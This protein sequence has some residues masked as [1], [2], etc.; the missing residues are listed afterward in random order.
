MYNGH[1]PTAR[2]PFGCN[3]HAKAVAV[4]KAN[5]FILVPESLPGAGAYLALSQL[6]P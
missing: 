1:S 4:S 2:S 3:G 6:F 5:G